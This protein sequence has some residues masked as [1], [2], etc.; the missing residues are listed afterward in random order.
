MKK[1]KIL[2]L[3]KKHN[4]SAG[5]FTSKS[6]LSNS[7]EFLKKILEK[8]FN[9]NC[10]LKLCLDANSINREIH[11][12]RPDICILEAIWVPPY[13]LKEL[14]KLWPEVTF[15]IRVHSKTPFLANEGIAID[16]IKQYNEIENV[17]ISFNNDDTNKDFINIGIKSVYLPNLYPV[18][19][20]LNYF[21][22]LF[23]SVK[24]KICNIFG[25]T[26]IDTIINIGCFGAIRPL[27]NQLSQAFAAISY[28]DSNNKILHYHINS[29]RVEQKGESAI[30]NI[31]ELFKNTR[32]KLIEYPWMN[33]HDF[34]KVIGKMDMGLQVS[35][36]ESFNI[37]TA[38]FINTKKPIIVGYDTDWVNDKS[39]VDPNDIP[40][41]T[42]KIN[43]V[44]N[45]PSSFTLRNYLSLE[46]YQFNSLKVWKDFLN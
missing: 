29:S 20:N 15:L 42:K 4:D 21:K 1:E 34:I 12:F 14:V 44:L 11:L 2:F 24:E 17:I 37:V 13:K 16:W 26:H 3:L 18:N 43:S 38:D 36:T 40:G 22:Y 9:V 23:K 19:N 33:H 8:N 7:A 45:N 41:M 46:K 31:R 30:K 6:G 28:A 5:Y 10:D 25:C 27:K 35:F 39:K 32:H